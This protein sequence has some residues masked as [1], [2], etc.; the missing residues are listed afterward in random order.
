MGLEKH[1]DGGVKARVGGENVPSLSELALHLPWCCWTPRDWALSRAH[2]RSPAL[3]GR[4]FVPRGTGVSVPVERYALAVRQRNSGLRRGILGAIERGARRSQK[5]DAA[6]AARQAVARSS[7]MGWPDWRP[8]S[9]MIWRALRWFFAL[10]GTKSC[11]YSRRWSAM[12][13]ATAL[14]GLLRSAR[15]G[16]TCG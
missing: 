6:D 5:P 4:H 10:A 15:I 11:R 1:R 9:P 3:A 16:L 7:L 14:K 8:P 13:R 12:R 2:L